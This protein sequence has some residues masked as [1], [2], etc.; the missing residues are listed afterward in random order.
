MER[1]GS[2]T[3]QDVPTLE[4]AT[5]CGAPFHSRPE[6]WMKTVSRHFWR[7][8]WQIATSCDNSM[9]NDATNETLRNNEYI[10]LFLKKVKNI[11]RN[12]SVKLA[13]LVFINYNKSRHFAEKKSKF[14]LRHCLKVN[15][16]QLITITLSSRQET[17]SILVRVE[18]G[19]TIIAE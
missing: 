3:S 16:S 13:L 9:C 12:L 8:P 18:R 6:A 15:L 11:L 14:L 2:G 4:R 19:P 7:T 10:F 5:L 17:D 1:N